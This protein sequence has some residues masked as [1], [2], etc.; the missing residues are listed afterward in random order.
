MAMT[1]IHIPQCKEIKEDVKSWSCLK[2]PSRSGQNALL[3]HWGE[4]PRSVFVTI[5]INSRLRSPGARGQS[6]SGALAPES[7]PHS[8]PSAC[9][10][11]LILPLPPV[12][13]P[14]A[15]PHSTSFPPAPPIPF[16]PPSHCGLK[17]GESLCPRRGFMAVSRSKSSSRPEAMAEGDFFRGAKLAGVPGHRPHGPM[18]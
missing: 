15:R 13:P 12:A 4:Q 8:A 14:T 6:K 11:V 5:P 16:C 7:W 10:P 3:Y 1:F 17:T 18:Q 2:G 9:E